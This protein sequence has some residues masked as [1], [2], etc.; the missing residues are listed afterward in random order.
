MIHAAAALVA[1]FVA[2]NVLLHLWRRYVRVDEP[3]IVILAPELRVAIDRG[4]AAIALVLRAGARAAPPPPL[5]AAAPTM[6][7]PT[8]AQ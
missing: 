6:R 1:L 8:G 7:A 2:A 5:M 4:D 3:A